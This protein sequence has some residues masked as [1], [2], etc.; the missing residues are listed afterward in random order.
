MFQWSFNCLALLHMKLNLQVV[1]ASTL[2]LYTKNVT[3]FSRA[4]NRFCKREMKSC[5][6]WPITDFKKSSKI[7]VAR[8]REKQPEWNYNPH[9][10]QSIIQ[11]FIETFQVQQNHGTASLHAN[12]DPVDVATNLNKECNGNSV[13]KLIHSISE[14][15]ARAFGNV[16]ASNSP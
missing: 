3:V 1:W 11:T 14:Q 4:R 16:S 2:P 10:I 12:F 6:A 5:T 8:A 7:I 15:T 13:K 9:L